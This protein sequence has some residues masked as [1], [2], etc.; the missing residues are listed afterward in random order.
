MTLDV[1]PPDPPSLRGPQSRGDYEAI[2]MDE[3]A[4]DDYRREEVAAVLE[5]GAWVDA[6]D[7]WAEQTYLSEPDFAAARDH[8][9]FEALD[10][11]WEPADDEV[12]YRSPDVPE[13]ARADFEDP[14]GVAAALDTL[15]RT[16]SEVLE[17]DYLRR[18]ENDF[19]FFA[20]QGGDEER[21]SDADAD[22]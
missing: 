8:G 11:Y 9:L 16:V 10:F 5:E 22:L 1:E 13:D 21:D 20:G 12:G 15:G 3:E 14:G 17:N 2:D 19:G 7:D 4:I 6:F 18:D